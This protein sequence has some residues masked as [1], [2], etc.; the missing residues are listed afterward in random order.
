MNYDEL[1]SLPA[2]RALDALVAEHV[3][4]RECYQIVNKDNTVS[5]RYRRDQLNPKRVPDYSTSEEVMWMVIRR[6]VFVLG[7]NIVHM[8]KN[9]ERFIIEIAKAGESYY[10]MDKSFNVA[11]CK[12]AIRSVLHI[13]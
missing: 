10:E 4:G 9:G 2:G 7:F 12:V 6:L 5:Y 11:L 13:V 8:S 3:F 1:K